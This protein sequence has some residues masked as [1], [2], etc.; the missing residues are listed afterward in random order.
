MYFYHPPM[1]MQKGNVFSRF[2][3]SVSHSVHGKLGPMWPLPMMHRTLPFGY[4]PPSRPWD[5]TELGPPAPQTCSNLFNMDLTVKGPPVG[6]RTVRFLLEYFL[7][8]CICKVAIK[9]IPKLPIITVPKRSL[10]RLCFYTCLSF[11]PRGGDV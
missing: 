2:C 8:R 6:K 10:R 7:I 9:R 3:P 5:L 1:K 4:P 11:C